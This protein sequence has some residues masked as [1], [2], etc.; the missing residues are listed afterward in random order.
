[1]WVAEKSLGDVWKDALTDSITGVGVKG[2]MRGGD[3]AAAELIGGWVWVC[4]LGEGGCFRKVSGFCV[5]GCVYE[6]VA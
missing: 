6:V 4:G 1:M 2:G 3:A 5:G